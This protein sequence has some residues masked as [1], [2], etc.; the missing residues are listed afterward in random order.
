MTYQKTH[1]H[2]PCPNHLK[3][4]PNTLAMEV[5]ARTPKSN[6]SAKA[7]YNAPVGVMNTHWELD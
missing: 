5:T 3:L 4:K 6:S 7:S 2:T 1:P